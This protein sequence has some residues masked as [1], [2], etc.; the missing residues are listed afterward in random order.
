M[1]N[2]PDFALFTAP[3]WFSNFVFFFVNLVVEYS[4]PQLNDSS[5]IVCNLEPCIIKT[6]RKSI[7]NKVL[8]NH[9]IRTPRVTSAEVCELHCFMEIAC[10]S[11]NFGPKEGGGHVC[12]LSDSDSIRDPLDWTTKQGFIYGG[13]KVLPILLRLDHNNKLFERTVVS[14]LSRLVSRY[15]QSVIVKLINVASLFF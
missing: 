2:K 7:A 10:Q 12:E 14:R 6:L 5:L 13:I 4:F 15:L 1:L 3:G 8:K 9:V 11:Y